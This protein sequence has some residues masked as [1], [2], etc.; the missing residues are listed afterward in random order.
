MAKWEDTVT[1]YPHRI[2]ITLLHVDHCYRLSDRRATY[3]SVG[4][5]DQHVA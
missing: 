1:L 5:G 3:G 4:P 2:F